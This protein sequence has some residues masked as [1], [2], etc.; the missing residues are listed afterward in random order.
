MIHSNKS[1]HL[2]AVRR[3]ICFERLS[4]R[5][6]LAADTGELPTLH[7][8][9]GLRKSHF[10][11]AVNEIRIEGTDRDDKIIVVRS[12]DANGAA[13]ITV[14]FNDDP[15]Q[16]FEDSESILI[17][18]KAGD[19]DIAY[20][21]IL[22]ATIHG[23]D[24]NDRILGSETVDLIYGGNGN[25]L[26]D[27]GTGNDAIFGGLGNDTLLGGNGDDAIHGGAG[28][29]L[30]DGG[31]NNDHLRG[32]KGRDILLGG[33]GHDRIEA[34]DNNEC[35]TEVSE[36]VNGR[37]ETLQTLVACG[38][39]QGDGE[40]DRL[41]GGEG[42]DSVWFNSNE[43]DTVE[44]AETIENKDEYGIYGTYARDTNADGSVTAADVSAVLQYLNA[45]EAIFTRIDS[46]DVNKDGKVTSYD[47]LLIINKL[48]KDSITKSI[49]AEPISLDGAAIEVTLDPLKQALQ[50]TILSIV[51]DSVDGTDMPA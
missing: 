43:G 20:S 38:G 26:I 37:V 28:D 10:N 32:G 27:G 21:G 13:L 3:Y 45:A 12:I 49:S 9:Y 18:G 23:G 42:T 40:A 24:G 11:E 50:K 15:A 48:N 29:D 8:S 2:I 14:T 39:P 34:T 31:S 19:D 17:D 36:I 46:L 6:M 33:D 44:L 4:S 16:V 25:D 7:V 41:I 1:P 47:A 30:I 22:A 5:M 51:H 35:N